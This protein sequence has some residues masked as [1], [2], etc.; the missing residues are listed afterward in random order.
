[1]RRS[2]GRLLRRSEFL[3]VA[4]EGLRRNTPAFTL[5][6]AAKNP[7]D[8]RRP[9]GFR[10]GLTVS[11]KVGNAVERNRA[12]RRLRAAADR[13]LNAETREIDVVV[14]ARRAAITR[15]FEQ[16]SADLRRTVDQAA[17]DLASAARR[18]PS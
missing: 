6:A 5:Q 9:S 10:L 7:S 16:L 15:D 12:K 8:E 18:K 11:R 4:G 1:M 2:W 13:V 3:R 14:I 17:R